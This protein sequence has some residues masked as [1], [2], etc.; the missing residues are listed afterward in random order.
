MPGR[1]FNPQSGH[2]MLKKIFQTIVLIVLAATMLFT[3]FI[4]LGLVLRDEKQLAPWGIGFFVIGS[5]S[6]RPAIP[7][8]SIIVVQA[9]PADSIQVGDVVSFSIAEG[10]AV[11]THRVQIIEDKEGAPVFVT[12]GDANKRYDAP[13]RYDKIIGRVI[14]TIPGNSKI[15]NLFKSSNS[16][17]TYVVVAGAVLCLLGVIGGL[18]KKKK[19]ADGEEPDNVTA[20]KTILEDS[21]CFDEDRQEEEELKVKGVNADENNKKIE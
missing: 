6:M 17:G 4:V 18:N 9:V 19:A 16:L 8:G 11:V 21:L 13:M 3:I 2:M 10:Q 15:L 1:K 12:K 20:E 14:Y 5:G 7:T